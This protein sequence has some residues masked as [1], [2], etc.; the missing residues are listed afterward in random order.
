LFWQ[1]SIG[2]KPSSRFEMVSEK[3]SME[4]PLLQRGPFP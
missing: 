4:A 1:D 2:L 3:A